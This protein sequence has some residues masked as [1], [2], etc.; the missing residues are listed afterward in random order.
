[1]IIVPTSWSPDI[2]AMLKENQPHLHA[3]DARPYTTLRYT[4]QTTMPASRIRLVCDASLSV[5]GV[6]VAIETPLDQIG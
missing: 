4:N 3:S 2:L 6:V 1:V 5:R